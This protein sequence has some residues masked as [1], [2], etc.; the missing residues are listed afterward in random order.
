MLLGRNCA[1]PATV[2]PS[3]RWKGSEDAVAKTT[4][5]LLDGLARRLQPDFD[6]LGEIREGEVLR[7]L[8]QLLTGAW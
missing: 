8:L 1:D 3:S 5:K 2:A 4:Q 7:L 6:R